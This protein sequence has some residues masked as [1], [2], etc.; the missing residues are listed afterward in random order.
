MASDWIIIIALVSLLGIVVLYFR[1]VSSEPPEQR[2]KGGSG[3]KS[4]KG[5]TPGH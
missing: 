2:R 4:A 5:T 3:R 1:S